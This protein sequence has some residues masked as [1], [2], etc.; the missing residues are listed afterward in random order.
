MLDFERDLHSEARTVLEASHQ[1]QNPFE[2]A[3]VLES[4]GY[5]QSAARRLG[6]P[7]VFDLARRVFE[8]IDLYSPSPAE[9]R[10][11]ASRP[12]QSALSPAPPGSAG[13]VRAGADQDRITARLLARC[14]FYSLPWLLAVIALAV[15]RVSFW[16]T[17]T[18]VQFSSAISLAL[19]VSLI[20]TGAVIQAF[21]RRGT[22][23]ALQGNRALLAWTTRWTLGG[24]VAAVVIVFVGMYFGLE[25][26]L[27]AYTP[28]ANRSFL[29]F[30]LSISALLLSLAPLYMARAFGLVTLAA[31]SGALF[32]IVAGKAITHG[33][34]ID[35]FVAMHVQ[36]VA[37]W[38]VVVLAGA[39]DWFVLRRFTVPTGAVAH[40]RVRPPHLGAAARSVAG[41]AA[42][43]AC[44]F[45]LIIADHLVVGGLWHGHFVYDGHYELAVGVGLLVLIPT[46]TYVAS[47]SEIF[48]GV[49]R[50]CL[51]RYSV[52][53]ADE[54]RRDMR[55]FYAGHLRTLGAVGLGAAGVLLV[56]GAAFATASSITAG[57]AGVYGI[58]AGALASY[59]LLSVGVLNAGLLFSLS[60]PA[61]PALAAV[62]GT[63][64]SLVVGGI[65]GA[66]W[67]IE[68]GALIGLLAGTALFA[69]LTTAV[70]TRAFRRFDATYYRAF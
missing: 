15:S 21:A 57:L 10:R 54:M 13:A 59:L 36:L 31:G 18:T 1:P 50:S 5:D 22:F 2:V 16:S 4:G 28:D 35:P 60:R 58:F 40:D 69:G 37:I 51:T 20:L 44:F 11:H 39:A 67:S 26:G 41:Y 3:V 38:I 61:A 33:N 14:V 63:V 29:W 7:D 32:V 17:I 34:Y 9:L 27:A 25:Y 46:L 45:L 6:S 19:F 55:A 62:A 48:P 42:Y 47:V 53:R 8:V 30:G 23:Y 49:V 12:H 66:R 52:S 24:G 43:G 70:T 65:L 56:A 64:V 68:G